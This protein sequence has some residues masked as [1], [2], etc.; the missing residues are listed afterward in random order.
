MLPSRPHGGGAAGSPSDGAVGDGSW[1]MGSRSEGENRES[2]RFARRCF[3][4]PLA[5]Q[6]NQLGGIAHRPLADAVAAAPLR[7]I[8]VN[9]V[10]MISVRGRPEHRA[11]A[12][13]RAC[14]QG[15]THLPGDRNVCRLVALA[16]DER[17]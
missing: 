8:N 16:V 7:K 1:L 17:Q 6:R 13:T 3:W 14:L 2:S 15:F 11:E 4:R 12:G 9:M 10:L 5:R